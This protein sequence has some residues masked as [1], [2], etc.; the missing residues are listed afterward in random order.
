MANTVDKVLG[1]D[2]T[3]WGTL[4]G[5]A[6]GLAIGNPA[7]GAGLGGAAGASIDKSK[8]SKEYKEARAK[9]PLED[10]T[11]LK[12]LNDFKSEA[13]YRKNSA[14]KTQV[15]ALTKMKAANAVGISQASGGSSGAALAA[16]SLDNNSDTLKQLNTDMFQRFQYNT[17]IM[18]AF[19]QQI[20]D[21]RLQLQMYDTSVAQ[22]V[23]ADAATN[24]RNMITGAVIAGSE[25]G[26]GRGGKKNENNAVLRWLKN[27]MF[28]VANKNA[29]ESYI[30]DSQF[31]D[32][33][34]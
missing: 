6:A 15:E 10:P 23:E 8:A 27:S 22:S 20:A 11:V 30:G 13:N 16:L 32:Q 3:S 4:I 14:D 2:A 7:L 25:Y 19:A 9:I 31:F 21:R 34:T 18:A 1:M 24:F 33:Y 29:G 17:G 26:T 12:F 5:G 28:K